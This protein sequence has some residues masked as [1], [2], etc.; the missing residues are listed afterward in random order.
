[1]KKGHKDFVTIITGL[2]NGN[3]LIL[4][5]LKGK[6]KQTVKNFLAKIPLRIRRTVETICVDLY[7]G[8]INAAKEIFSKKTKITADRFHVAKLYRNGLENLRKKELKRLKKLLSKEDYLSLKGVMWVLRKNKEHLSPEE[9]VQLD[10]LFSLSPQLKEAY[11]LRE[12]LTHLFNEDINKFQGKHRINSW[13]RKVQ[14]S[15]VR[16]FDSF[17]K[18]LLKFKDEI[19]NYFINRRSSGFV[20]GLNNKI[21][22]IKRRCYGVL[23]RKHLFQR[24]YLDISGYARFS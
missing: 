11:Q 8:F 23:N 2:T 22:V 4:G 19:S 10:F 12:S 16:C 24:I 21:K 6:K 9:K 3:L 15:P 17:I 1:L 5:V 14:R 18:T 13:I 20:E 7:E